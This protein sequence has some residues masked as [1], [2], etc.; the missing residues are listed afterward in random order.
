MFKYTDLPL[1]KD[2]SAKFIPWVVALM[3]YLAT[4]AFICAMTTTAT[5]D[6][7]DQG[8]YSKITVEIPPF[9]E[10]LKQ[11][12]QYQIQDS[13]QKILL[14]LRKVPDI[15]SFRLLNRSEVLSML[16]PW[17]GD[18]QQFQ[19]LPLSTFIDIELDPKIEIELTQFI[20][21]IQEIVPTARVE[22]HKIWKSNLLNIAYAIKIIGLIIVLLVIVASFCVVAF[23]SQTSLII[24]RRIIEILHLIGAKNSYIAKQFR[25]YAFQL[26]M[27]GSVFSI[28]L[29]ALTLEG[30]SY[31]TEGLDISFLTNTISTWDLWAI[32]IFMPA[33]ITAFMMFSAR[34]TV[35]FMLRKF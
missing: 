33:M 34:F 3:T 14:Y 27:I 21:N 29:T 10:D 23:I 6:Q 22:S 17:F 4:I 7:W 2:P 13:S 19:N 11:S 32:I 35:S 12:N 15:K 28:A 25:A 30:I 26:G 18:V 1:W 5:I 20:H 24:H 16:Q 8:S 9:L 31:L